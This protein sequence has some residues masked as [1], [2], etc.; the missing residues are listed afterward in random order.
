LVPAVLWRGKGSIVAFVW[1][2]TETYRVFIKE[3]LLTSELVTLIGSYEGVN[4]YTSGI[5]PSSSSSS[6]SSSSWGARWHSG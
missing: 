4:L 3:P 2:V 1:E 5:M 6:S